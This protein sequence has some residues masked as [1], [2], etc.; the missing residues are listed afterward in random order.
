[1]TREEKLEYIA[2]KLA[3]V[4]LRAQGMMD[5]MGEVDHDAIAEDILDTVGG[6][7]E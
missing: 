3:H 5:H 7:S 2:E 1:M 4:E 6:P